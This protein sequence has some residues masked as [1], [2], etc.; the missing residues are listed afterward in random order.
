MIV[1]YCTVNIYRSSQ[2][3]TRCRS[4]TNGFQ[5]LDVPS[6]PSF[7]K[8]PVSKDWA[9]SGKGRRFCVSWVEGVWAFPGDKTNRLVR[10]RFGRQVQS[11]W[12]F[13]NSWGA[14][15]NPGWKRH[16]AWKMSNARGLTKSKFIINPHAW[17]ELNLCII[18]ILS[19]YNY[20]V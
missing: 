6:W 17:F 4:G 20:N 1:T 16:S 18:L 10:A 11:T 5:F 13:L 15:A 7:C 2:G 14:F 9:D 3:D 8:R 12:T 19:Y